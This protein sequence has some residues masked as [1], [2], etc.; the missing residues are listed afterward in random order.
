MVI[1]AVLLDHLPGSRSERPTLP[2]DDPLWDVIEGCWAK[3]P[4]KRP[5]MTHIV[6]IVGTSCNIPSSADV[7][8]SWTHSL[9]KIVLG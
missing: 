4:P 8:C 7:S 3:E 1:R 9:T 5:T 2:E 6:E